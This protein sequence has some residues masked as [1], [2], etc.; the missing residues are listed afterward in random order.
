MNSELYK[1]KAQVAKALAHES[2][3][4]IL[5]DLQDRDRCV[6]ELTALVGAPEELIDRILRRFP[7]PQAQTVRR[8]LNHPGPIPL[9]DVE[10]ARRQISERARRLAVEGKIQLPSPICL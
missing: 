6:C 7:E 8:R 5:D 2:R 10:D 1:L 4:M 3:L 9:S